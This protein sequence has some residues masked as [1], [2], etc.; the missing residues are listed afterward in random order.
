M[1]N[2]ALKKRLYPIWFLAACAVY[3]GGAA[4][5]F[6]TYL[7]W[8]HIPLVV[9][10]AIL[11]VA[12][13]SG[14]LLLA[15]TAGEKELSDRAKLLVF[16]ITNV[17]THAGLW[18]LLAVV[19]VD[20]LYNR[21]A[22][23]TAYFILMPLFLLF[24]LIMLHRIPK[25]GIRLVNKLLA[26]L[27]MVG[28]L[29][30]AM[31]PIV[32]DPRTFLIKCL[33]PGIPSFDAISA[34]AMTVTEEEK[35]ECGE[36]FDKHILLEGEKLT[37]AFSFDLGGVS[38]R[39][40]VSFYN[41]T[42]SEPQY[43]DAGG[44]TTVVTLTRSGLEV[45]V[46]G[47][48]YRDKASCEWTVYLKNVGETNTETLSDVL[49]L[50]SDFSLRSP[51][52]YYSKGSQCQA[53]DFLMKKAFLVP[54]IPLNFY[55]EGGRSSDGYLPYFN[56]SGRDGGVVAAIGWTGEWKNDVEKTDEGAHL[57]V[58][59]R[60]LSAYLTPGE[61]IRTP[62]VSLTFYNSK[63]P[64]KGFNMFRSFLADCVMPAGVSHITSFVLADEFSTLTAQELIDKAYAIPEEKLAYFNN[65][66][67]DAGWYDYQES[68]WDGVGTWSANRQ[69][70]PNS[71]IEVG[72][73]AAAMGKRYLLW[74]E[75]ERVRR[76]T[77]LYNEGGRHN[78]WLIGLEDE[79]NWLWNLANDDAMDFLTGYITAALQE[80][81]V[82]VYRQDFNFAPLE[83]WQKA[84]ELFYGG[85]TGIAENHYIANYY[86]YLDGL[87]A[88]N[89]GLIM[90][91]CSSG[92]RRLDLEMMARSVPL[93]RSDYNCDGTRPDILEATQAMTYGLSFWLPSYGTSYY[94]QD[95]Y[96]ARSSIMPCCSTGDGT[97]EFIGAY[98]EIRDEMLE[99]YYP[100]TKGG[101]KE[102]DALGMQFGNPAKGHALVYVRPKYK[103]STLT[104]CFSG[105]VSDKL[106]TVT[107]LDDP[108]DVTEM[109]GS[110]LM[111]S[112]FTVDAT[113][114]RDALIYIYQLKTQ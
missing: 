15:V 28:M 81:G 9:L 49:A 106:Y 31:T 110:Q 46:V 74:F 30:A 23:Y 45:R 92:G 33:S 99:N 61:E 95:E 25:L 76:D 91:N 6:R 59:Q 94:T 75:P 2:L 22:I 85:R 109:S 47:T 56:I 41:L 43:D 42:R 12:G 105:L 1:K 83:Y 35:E 52:V 50:D 93:W 14:G 51:S 104:F 36:W 4:A 34:E 103:E 79:D 101:A 10:S 108:T 60:D 77:Y 5:F 97:S 67:M 54:T 68:W 84:D 26:L 27:C 58:G 21:R 71:L 7:D 107:N 44:E 13:F 80:N 63:V 38:L 98:E 18:T 82:T 20:G 53:E 114:K 57:A 65:F 32:R 40:T 62:R 3:F 8:K 96:A 69:K 102:T 11:M 55:P 112:G 100:L 87:F 90:D 88:N 89:P 39:D 73:A 113:Q 66:W 72:N 16:L 78:D 111:K 70:F 86:R 64:L 24:A 17:L 29:A 19:N 48:L 37:P